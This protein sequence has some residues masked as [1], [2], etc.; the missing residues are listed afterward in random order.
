MLKIKA[1]TIDNCIFD[2]GFHLSEEKLLAVISI[3]APCFLLRLL[4]FMHRL[5]PKSYAAMHLQVSNIPHVM[6][7]RYMRIAM[8]MWLCSPYMHVSMLHIHIHSQNSTLFLFN[9]IKHV[10]E[11]VSLE[12]KYK[13]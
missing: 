10:S 1:S 11:V 8:P 7:A 2:A 12:N 9:S 13:K 5:L 3:L 4:L 6:F